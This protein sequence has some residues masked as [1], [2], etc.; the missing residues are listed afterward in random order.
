MHTFVCP[1]L[2]QSWNY[3]FS[4]RDTFIH[5]FLGLRNWMRADIL[6]PRQAQAL[7]LPVSTGCLLSSGRSGGAL[8]SYPPQHPM[9]KPLAEPVDVFIYS[10]NML[11][12]WPHLTLFPAKS[13]SRESLSPV[14]TIKMIS[15]HSSFP[16]ENLP[17]KNSQPWP[18]LPQKHC[19]PSRPD[20]VP[21]SPTQPPPWAT[22]AHHVCPAPR[23]SHTSIQCFFPHSWPRNT[24]PRWLHGLLPSI[25]CLVQILLYVNCQYR[26]PQESNSATSLSISRNSFIF[27]IT[28]STP[29]MQC[30]YVFLICLSSFKSMLPEK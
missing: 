7:H 26:A 19:F 23:C 9:C 8:H 1:I 16:L 15:L 21:Q 22:P 20:P 28:L 17:R 3:R 6:S 29:D 12:F 13:L 4:P 18:L 25:S 11:R 5:L 2:F 14:L 27:L 30:M 10:Q 24:S